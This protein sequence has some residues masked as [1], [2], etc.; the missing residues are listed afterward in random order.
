MKNRKIRT[1][2]TTDKKEIAFYAKYGVK[3]LFENEGRSY[4]DYKSINLLRNLY[5][6]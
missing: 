2:Y 1:N 5:K 3:P 4:Y 6:G